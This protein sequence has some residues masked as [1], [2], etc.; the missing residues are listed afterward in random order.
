MQTPTFR[1]DLLQC[2]NI[3]PWEL[4]SSPIWGDG[5]GPQSAGW[6]RGWGSA[7]RL[8]LAVELG[9][10]PGR[11]LGW[12]AAAGCGAEV[13]AGAAAGAGAQAGAGAEAGAGAAAGK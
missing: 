10:G 6:G 5:A 1:N 7:G 4:I 8:R 9:L 3:V 2:T 13:G 12:K 11:R